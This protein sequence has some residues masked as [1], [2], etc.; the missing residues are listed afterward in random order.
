MDVDSAFVETL[1]TILERGRPVDI[2]ES[3]SVAAGRRT[4]EILDHSFEL[5]EPRARLLHDAIRRWNP[6][7]AVGR[8]VWMLA[9]SDR[10]SD[11]EFYDPR[12]AAFSDDGL[13]IPGSSDGA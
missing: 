12:A 13:T 8:L 11:I 7:R 1:A 4:I 6:F 9:G 5:L 3:L 10:V 2:G